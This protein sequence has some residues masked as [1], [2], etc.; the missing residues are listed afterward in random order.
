MISFMIVICN[1]A[2]YAVDTDLYCN[3]I[4]IFQITLVLLI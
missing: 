4:R 2:I 1:I 3:V